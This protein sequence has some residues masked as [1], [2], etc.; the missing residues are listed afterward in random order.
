LKES[1]ADSLQGDDEDVEP[2]LLVL[3]DGGGVVCSGNA[4]VKRMVAV[5][6]S[7]SRLLTEK[8]IKGG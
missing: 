2:Q 5:G 4:M 8:K 6:F 7:P 3:S 1:Q